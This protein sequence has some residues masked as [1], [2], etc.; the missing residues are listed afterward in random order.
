MH[1]TNMYIA[2]GLVAAIV[3][4]SQCGCGKKKSSNSPPIALAGVNLEVNGGEIVQLDGSGSRDPEGRELT[5]DWTQAIGPTVK[6]SSAG[7]EKPTF[8]A[9]NEIT[10]IIFVLTVSDG[11]NLSP[12]S[13]ATVNVIRVSP[14]VISIWP[15]DG[16][17]SVGTDTSIV[18]RFS[19]AMDP[20]TLSKSN[21]EMSSASGKPALSI[22]YET[23]ANRA[24]IKLAEKLQYDAEHR[25]SLT[26]GIKNAGGTPIPVPQVVKFN[27]ATKGC[28]SRKSGSPG[29]D[30]NGD[31]GTASILK[32]GGDSYMAFTQ[33]QAGGSAKM[34][35]GR[36]DGSEWSTPWQPLNVNQAHDAESPQLGCTGGNAF[37]AW[38]EGSTQSAKQVY[39]AG[40]D[41]GE[42]KRLGSSLNTDASRNAM[43][44]SLTDTGNVLYAAWIE[45]SQNQ[46]NILRTAR[47][48]GTKWEMIPQATNRDGAANASSPDIAYDEVGDKFYLAWAEYS[49]ASNSRL[50][51]VR[52]A[53][54]AY[55]MAPDTELNS[56][57]SSDAADPSISAKGG[58]V[59][60]AWAETGLDGTSSIFVK[61]ATS[62]GWDFAGTGQV[63]N[64]KIFTLKNAG[65][66]K[67]DLYSG[68]P[69]VG[70]QE[71]YYSDAKAG[72]I[73]Q[74]FTASLDG[75]TWKYLGCGLF[76][77]TGIN[78]DYQ[79]DAKSPC[80]AYIDGLPYTVF[81]QST[82]PSETDPASAKLIV[83]NLN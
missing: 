71:A 68:T 30:W 23:P 81:T 33:K 64:T 14:L 47:W 22:S 29:A 18:I 36:W 50:L 79:M 72:Y 57:N 2:A 25:I 60:V 8:T 48:T 70:W 9:P 54:G 7:S 40:L 69:L 66:P 77:G 1:K 21:I 38:S 37:A 31:A 82:A 80:V 67:L 74:V 44:P 62:S 55:W 75:D 19:E 53:L 4:F 49:A 43:S 12:T 20:A 11:V 61:K 5:Y 52:R 65:K 10:S 27:T 3:A 28:W 26:R 41:G 13:F 39:V 45:W 34:R 76:S 78:E 35:M 73:Y 83:K 63:N 24:V 17:S 42:W 16:S 59:F 46:P 56:S 51:L 32:C 6:L 15:A 58:S